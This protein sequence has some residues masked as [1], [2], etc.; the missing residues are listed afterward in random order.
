M[1]EENITQ[2]Q[3]TAPAPAAATE[4]TTEP[5]QQQTSIL[6]DSG[7]WEFDEY[8]NDA[9]KDYDHKDFDEG[10]ITLAKANNLSKEQ[11]TALR[12]ALLDKAIAEEV[13]ESKEAKDKQERELIELQNAW[14]GQFNF[15][16]GQINKLL[17][18]MDGGNQEGPV[19]KYL[20]E[21][22]LDS[23]TRFVKF[24]DNIVSLI[25][26]EDDTKISK[27][28]DVVSAESVQSE[29]NRLMRDPAY[30]NAGDPAHESVVAQVTKLYERLYTD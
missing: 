19:H 28:A 21:S 20:A 16:V 17:L 8:M 11:A 30:F 5:T 7:N 29:I 6:S 2:Q 26:K 18:Q 10:F 24:M 13:S 22:G 1:S 3:T 12:K 27:K 23:D 9:I 4:A 15:R 25:S 14:G